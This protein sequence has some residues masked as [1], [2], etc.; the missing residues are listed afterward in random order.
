MPEACDEDVYL[1]WI[2]SDC[3]GIK[4]L[5]FYIRARS[6]DDEC[7]YIPRD[8]SLDYNQLVPPLLASALVVGR[9]RAGLSAIR[10]AVL[11]DLLQVGSLGVP[12]HFMGSRGEGRRH[13]GGTC[14]PSGLPA[15]L[16]LGRENLPNQPH[17]PG[18]HGL[19]NKGLS[20]AALT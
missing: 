18:G 2:Q 6:Q 9:G 3:Q 10:D 8:W 7:S 12:G 16:F 17:L 20:R 14:K 11:E 4:L 19:R 5:P 13:K 1:T 15:A